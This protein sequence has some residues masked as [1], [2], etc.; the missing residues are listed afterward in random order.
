MIS[1]SV[2]DA[3]MTVM[4]QT[5]AFELSQG[6]SYAATTATDQT[7]PLRPSQVKSEPDVDS[8]LAADR[9][10]PRASLSAP[11]AAPAPAG[12]E[13]LTKL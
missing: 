4:N 1:R 2:A 3:A 13:T 5:W 9:A 8:T 12:D 6:F 10:R 7:R 11:E